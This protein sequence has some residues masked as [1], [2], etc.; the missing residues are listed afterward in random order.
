M[1]D[2]SQDEALHAISTIAGRPLFPETST[3]AHAP[4]PAS[5][6]GLKADIPAFPS[7]F[8]AHQWVQ[9][10]LGSVYAVSGSGSG[11]SGTGQGWTATSRIPPD[12]PSPEWCMDNRTRG[13]RVLI[14]GL[15]GMMPAWRCRKLGHDCGVETNVREEEGRE[16]VKRLPPY[17]TS[18]AAAELPD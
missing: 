16:D 6:L 17:V 11:A 9:G 3:W 5:N 8:N 15:P 10:Q 18:F 12:R 4:R 7:A 14:R 1:T 13:R 2:I